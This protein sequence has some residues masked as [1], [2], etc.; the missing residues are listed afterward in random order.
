MYSF[1]VLLHWTPH[2]RN[3]PP[4]RKRGT[5]HDGSVDR[6]KLTAVFAPDDPLREVFQDQSYLFKI[7][8]LMDAI[9]YL[10]TM[11]VFTGFI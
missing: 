5:W 9:P 10:V 2:T 1:H 11:M 6:A 3:Y 8:V 7:P 4:N